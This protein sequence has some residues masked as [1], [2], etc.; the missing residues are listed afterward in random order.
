MSRTP[1]LI[2]V[3][4]VTLGLGACRKT[5]DRVIEELVARQNPYPESSPLHAPFDRALRELAGDKRFAALTRQ[6]SEASRNAGFDLALKGTARLDHATLERRMEILNAAV[7]AAAP[8]QCAAIAR[9]GESGNA[10]ATSTAMLQALEK[11]PPAQID[12][13]FRISLQASRAELDKKPATTVAS[14]DAEAAMQAL[15]DSLPA[16]QRQRLSQI[17]PRIGQANDEDA[18]WTTRTLLRQSL[19]LPEPHRGRLAWVFAQP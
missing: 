3:I 11:L 9:G 6:G 13:W 12:A 16:E 1:L 17:A 4:A 2:L 14:G 7:V 15:L 10:Q 5:E 18:C 19:S 8:A